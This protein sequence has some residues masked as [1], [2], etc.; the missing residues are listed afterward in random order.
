MIRKHTVKG[1]KPRKL[2]KKIGSR[3]KI[4]TGLS[5]PPEE[6]P[7]FAYITR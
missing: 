7:L 1:M 3:R 5:G 2:K 4:Q 6:I